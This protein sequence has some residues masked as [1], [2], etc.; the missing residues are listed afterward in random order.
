MI[1]FHAK[2][3]KSAK[4]LE[5]V[6]QVGAEKPNTLFDAFFASWRE[7][8][9]FP[10]EEGK[11]LEVYSST[12]IP[13]RSSSYGGQASTNEDTKPQAPGLKP[14]FSVRQRTAKT[15]IQDLKPADPFKAETLQTPHLRQ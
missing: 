13:L 5:D 11:G 2:L 15:L 12:S 7:M 1:K 10:A 6:V 3:A 14:M 4:G 9:S 8:N